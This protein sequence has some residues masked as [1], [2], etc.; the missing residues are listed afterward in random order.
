MI[1][2]ADIVEECARKSVRQCVVWRWAEQCPIVPSPTSGEGTVWRAPS[3]LIHFACGWI[4]SD[5]HQTTCSYGYDRDRHCLCPI[6]SRPGLPL[7][8]NQGDPAL[9]GGLT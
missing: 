9:H 6:R 5:D 3:Q 1:A 2:R 4:R 7:E 8:A